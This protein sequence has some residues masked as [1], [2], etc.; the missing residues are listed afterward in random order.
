MFG[1][2]AREESEKYN[3]IDLLIVVSDGIH[4]RQTAQHLYQKVRS[5]VVPIDFAKVTE[6]DH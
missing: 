3:D 2:A 6:T 4:R 1:S 5:G